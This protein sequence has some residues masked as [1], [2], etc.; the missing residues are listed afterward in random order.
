MRLWHVVAGTAIGLLPGTA[1]TT[2]FGE[3]IETALTGAGPVNW[4][5]VGIA[6]GLLGG[7]IV[8]VKRWFMRMSRR[9]HAVDEQAGREPR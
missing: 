4:W 9:I 8:A 6:V 7:G 5:L 1:A 3:A 2:L